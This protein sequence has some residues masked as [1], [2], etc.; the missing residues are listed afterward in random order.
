M[1]NQFRLA[2]MAKT[3]W[4]VFLSMKRFL[5]C[6]VFSVFLS[7]CTFDDSDDVRD[8][9]VYYK[10]GKNKLALELLEPKAYKDSRA[11]LIVGKIYEGMNDSEENMSKAK[12]YYGLSANL[13]NKN[14]EYRLALLRIKSG[15]DP[16]FLLLKKLGKVKNIEASILLFELSYER[17]DSSKAI[18]YLD[19]V[20]DKSYFADFLYRI[21]TDDNLKELKNHR[22]MAKSGDIDSTLIFA[23]VLM[24][25]ASE[26]IFPDKARYW[27]SLVAE[28]S[29]EA[30]YK[31]AELYALGVG[32]QVQCDR[33]VN[34]LDGVTDKSNEEFIK[35]RR[36][37]SNICLSGG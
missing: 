14:A 23:D 1:I 6:A 28:E 25:K 24:Q 33:A 27:Y 4:Y 15:D 21:Y 17:G 35:A 19:N 13:G 26:S 10:I 11:A 32:G 5:F 37:V 29:E 34:L 7:A 12:E 3:I 30:K 36:S 22:E 8:G 31:L 9:Y 16:E 2:W 18:Q 20:R